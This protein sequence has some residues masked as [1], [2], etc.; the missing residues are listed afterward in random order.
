MQGTVV[1]VSVEPGQT[2][3]AGD[4]VI[5]MEAMKMENPLR[6]AVSGT[7]AAVRVVTGQVVPAGT[8]LVEIEPIAS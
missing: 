1:K 2:V 4:V 3:S 8:V 6:A 5:V 7:V